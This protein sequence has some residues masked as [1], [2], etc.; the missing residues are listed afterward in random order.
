MMEKLVED[1][2][3]DPPRILAK[4]IDNNITAICNVITRS[5]GLVSGSMTERGIQT[6]VLAAKNLKLAVFML[7]H[8]E[9]IVSN[10]SPNYLQIL[11]SCKK[12]TSLDFMSCIYITYNHCL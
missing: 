9:Q 10:K 4:L 1:K 11:A 5:C 2:G 12:K 6:S 3:I 7:Q 8:C